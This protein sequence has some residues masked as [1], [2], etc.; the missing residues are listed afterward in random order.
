MTADVEAALAAIRQYLSRLPA[1][2]HG[3]TAI[4]AQLVDSARLFTSF[5]APRPPAPRPRVVDLSAWI[6]ARARGGRVMARGPA[7]A[8]PMGSMPS[9]RRNL[10]KTILGKS[11]GRAARRS[12]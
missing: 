9:A 2:Y 11:A 3:R 8:A 10:G 12:T 6:K 4:L 7:S 5:C 1:D